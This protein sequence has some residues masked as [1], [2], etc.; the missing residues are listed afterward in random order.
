MAT[1]PD[2]TQQFART[3]EDILGDS[4]IT[5]DAVTA[6]IKTL[7]SLLNKVDKK[8]SDGE[9]FIP[10]GFDDAYDF[11]GVRVTTFHSTEIPEIRRV[12]E[13]HFHIDRVVDKAAETRVAGGFGYGSLHLICRIPDIPEDSTHILIHD[14][15]EY[16][17]QVMEVQIRTVLQHAWAEFEHDIRYKGPNTG[18]DPRIDRA[19]T[20]AAGLIELA[21]Q[22]FDQIAAISNHNP[23]ATD[24]SDDAPLSAD[25]LP[26]VLTVI[27]GPQFPRSRSEYY[28]YAYAMLA[29]HEI[30]DVGG[31]RELLSTDLA[32]D[33]RNVMH[34]DF[35]PGQVRMVDD[36][37]LARYG[38]DHIKKTV[39]IGDHGD[40]RSGRL[41][42]RWKKL[43]DAGLGAAHRPDN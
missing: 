34:P 13:Q 6:R 11:I 40:T 22:Q 37:L 31:L 19:F 30:R 17:G 8:T 3:I 7:P 29:A 35:P 39:S 43:L 15:A 1:H 27:L 14:L 5:F 10:G 24:S 32:E 38:R 41:G 12:L 4:G 18:S 25:I 2:A 33:V 20:L 21:D 42:N 26:G 36:V 16:S 28:R 23:R 9:W